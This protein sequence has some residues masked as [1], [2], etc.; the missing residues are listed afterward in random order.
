MRYYLP[1]LVEPLQ[2]I[3][4]NCVACVGTNSLLLSFSLK[5]LLPGFQANLVV[6][7]FDFHM[8]KPLHTTHI[9]FLQFLKLL[10]LELFVLNSFHELTDIILFSI[11]IDLIV[12]LVLS[13]VRL[14][15]L[16]VLDHEPLLELAEHSIIRLLEYLH[17]FIVIGKLYFFANYGKIGPGFDTAL[18]LFVLELLL[19]AF[20]VSSCGFHGLITGPFLDSIYDVTFNVFAHVLVRLVTYGAVSDGSRWP[21]PSRLIVLDLFYHLV[22]MRV[23]LSPATVVT[24]LDLR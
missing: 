7:R 5:V 19:H 1:I 18:R 6:I 24:H 14:L 22:V 8:E 15:T 20:A 10:G 21:G 9:L 16:L 13:N 4:V 17:M 12:F 3:S 11:Q 2:F 23:S